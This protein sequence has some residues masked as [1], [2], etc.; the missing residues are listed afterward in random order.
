MRNLLLV[1]RR[2]YLEQIRGRAFRIST[3]LVP[4]LI[5]FLLGV[6]SFTGR[7]L[8]SGRHIAI[9]A[10]NASLAADI[11]SELLS[12]KQ[13]RYTVDTVAP[14]TPQDRADLQ[15]RLANK[16][17]DG[18]LIIDNSASATPSV[19]YESQSSSDLLDT[20]RLDPGDQRGLPQSP[21]RPKGHFQLPGPLPRSIRSA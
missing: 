2:E 12:D 3:I 5:L 6:S 10:D 8:A 20:S 16:T 17:L 9:A 21:S 18:L 7:K 15:A 1:A 14:F 19:T 13:A 4:M 11:R